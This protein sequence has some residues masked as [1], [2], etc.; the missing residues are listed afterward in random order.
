MQVG[1]QLIQHVR[2]GFIRQGSSLNAYCRD[3][4]IDNSNVYKALIGNWNGKK[5]KA[6][7]DKLIEAS[8]SDVSVSENKDS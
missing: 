6:L 8:E 3:N 2:A 4:S 1:K 5:A 7:R